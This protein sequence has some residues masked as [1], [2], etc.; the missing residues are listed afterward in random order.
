MEENK[1]ILKELTFDEYVQLSI[2]KNG[3]RPAWLVVQGKYGLELR[4]DYLKNLK[5][6]AKKEF[7]TIKSR[8]ID[9]NFFFYDEKYNTEIDKLKPEFPVPS[10]LSI[11]QFD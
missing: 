7:P 2:L 8:E 10:H 9:N 5:K 3:G 1:R 4:K 11:F 6:L